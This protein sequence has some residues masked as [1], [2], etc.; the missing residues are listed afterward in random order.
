M[1]SAALFDICGI[2]PRY[3]NLWTASAT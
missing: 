1:S 2:H 3:Q